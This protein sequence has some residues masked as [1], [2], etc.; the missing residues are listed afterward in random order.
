MGRPSDGQT[1]IRRH[2]VDLI[3]ER[4]IRRPG[5][6]RITADQRPPLII[7]QHRDVVILGPIGPKI[8]QRRMGMRVGERAKGDLAPIIRANH[9]FTAVIGM[10]RGIVRA[11]IR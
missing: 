6:G 2:L 3:V 5:R 9:G 1:P 11:V 4:T 8:N 7:G 10:S